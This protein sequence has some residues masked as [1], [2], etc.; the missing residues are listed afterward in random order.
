M[1][2]FEIRFNI[3]LL[4]FLFFNF[5]FQEIQECPKNTPIKYQNECILRFCSELEI[6]NGNCV[7]NNDII[8]TQWL[9]NIILIGDISYKYSDPYFD[10]NNN[11]I[12][13]TYPYDDNEESEIYRSRIFYGIQK[14]GRP[15]FY[16]KNKGFQSK[17]IYNLSYIIPKKITKA[18][19][20]K[21]FNVENEKKYYNLAFLIGTSDEYTELYEFKSH[22]FKRGSI[23]S[24]FGDILSSKR[25]YIE[26]SD[27]KNETLLAYIGYKSYSYSLL[28]KGFSFYY[29]STVKIMKYSYDKFKQVSNTGMCSCLRTQKNILGCFFVNSTNLLSFSVFSFIYG[30]ID[31]EQ[32][33]KLLSTIIIDNSNRQENSNLFYKCILLKEEIIV[34]IYFFKENNFYLKISELISSNQYSLNAIQSININNYDINSF[35]EYCDL[36]K[37][38]DNR[39]L[40]ASSSNNKSF[41]LLLIFDLFNNNNNVF[42][43]KYNIYLALYNLEYYIGLRG[44]VFNNYI[45]LT[46][47][48]MHF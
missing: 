19:S 23:T 11:L 31:S 6:L 35:Y 20:I 30:Y 44:L 13:A 34:F 17:K 26:T 40:F 29:N 2:Y 42:I 33:P 1:A 10:L 46:F 24:F 18:I 39:F 38:N 47:S 21:A 37:I 48:C 22:Y 32:N 12:I 8:N 16:D 3:H 36:I 43:R 9:N 14:N 7:I 41:L 15:L 25:F 45:G 4:L 5:S 28:F 27:N